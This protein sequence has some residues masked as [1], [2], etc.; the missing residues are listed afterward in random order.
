MGQNLWGMEAGDNTLAAARRQRV[1][2]NRPKD[3]E[4]RDK[5]IWDQLAEG[6]TVLHTSVFP[7]ASLA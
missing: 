2:G 5:I 4:S 3:W 7:R 6:Q 1:M